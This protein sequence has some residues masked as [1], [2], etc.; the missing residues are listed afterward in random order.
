[1][2]ETA[3]TYLTTRQVAERLGKSVATVKRM[4]ADGRLPHA[5]KVPGDTGAYLFERHVILAL[6]EGDGAA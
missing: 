2:S 3:H 4:A 6:V 1:M 5:V